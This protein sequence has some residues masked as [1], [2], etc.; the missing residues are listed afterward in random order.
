MKSRKIFL[1]A[2][3]IT[4]VPTCLFPLVAGYCGFSSPLVVVSL[5]SR[6]LAAF[7]IIS[8]HAAII[9]F[10]K[11]RADKIR[12]APADKET[13]KILEI[14]VRSPRKILL[15]SIVYG[16]IL[17]VS[18]VYGRLSG[19]SGDAVLLFMSTLFMTGIPFYILFIRQFEKSGSQFPFD[20]RYLSMSLTLRF[21]LV[22]TLTLF[23]MVS[24][25]ILSVKYFN[26]SAGI[27]DIN[28]EIILRIL[29]ING[30][31]VTLTVINILLLFTGIKKRINDCK[32]LAVKLAGGNLSCENL[33]IDSRDELGYLKSSL[34]MVKNNT[35][36]LVRGITLQFRA[37]LEIKDSLN[38]LAGGNLNAASE[39]AGSMTNLKN[40]AEVLNRSAADT[41]ESSSGLSAQI[42]NTFNKITEQADLVKKCSV[43]TN[44]MLSALNSISASSR[45]K[46]EKARE[47]VGVSDDENSSLMETVGYIEEVKADIKKIH[48]I[49]GIISDISSRTNMLAMNAAIEA[50]HA[51][52]AGK[53]FGVVAED[54][55]KLADSTARSSYEISQTISDITET[56]SKVSEIGTSTADNYSRV[57]RDIVDV[58]ES[59]RQIEER[60]KQ[61]NEEGRDLFT[62]SDRL[63]LISENVLGSTAEMRKKIEEVDSVV[64][65]L[66]RISDETGNAVSAAESGTVSIS[67][68]SEKLSRLTEELDS[69]SR[70]IGNEINRFTL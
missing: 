57:H 43:T 66:K 52:E 18:A 30:A 12:Q 61:I 22:I 68:S 8:Y 23:A 41:V 60:V 46:I 56:V 70:L 49:V 63:G 34:N 67:G 64:S 37:H 26:I 48:D 36:A 2:F 15:A 4:A 29:P 11:K 69:S 45:E 9:V 5:Y 38:S 51:G 54:I 14:I 28:R 17:P 35:L 62:L 25:Q 39:I 53:G 10:L 65:V 21:T 3:L 47:L 7:T 27:K 16:F 40:Q 50:A 59:F 55:R 24:L 44:R 58:I 1:N 20:S 33:E 13:E 31:G 42:E 6:L 32:L 19:A